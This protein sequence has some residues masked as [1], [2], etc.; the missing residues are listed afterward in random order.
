MRQWNAAAGPPLEEIISATTDF[1]P[2]S[3]SFVSF[4]T[5]SWANLGYRRAVRGGDAT[6][7]RDPFRIIPSTI[8]LFKH[9]VVTNSAPCRYIFPE[10][11]FLPGR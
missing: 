5:T 1:F 7:S 8:H 10:A 3:C 9:P 6:S 2:F 11:L 4:S